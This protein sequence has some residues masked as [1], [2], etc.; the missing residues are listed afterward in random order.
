M[1]TEIK[2]WFFAVATAV[3]EFL[4]DSPFTRYIAFFEDMP[5]LGHL[6]Y[7][8]PVA[9]MIAIGQAWLVCIAIF[10]SYQM[11]MRLINL[12]D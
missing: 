3:L 6:N 1:L 8:I 9:E 11:I 4:P 5:Y 12:I 10:Y 7:F 2:S